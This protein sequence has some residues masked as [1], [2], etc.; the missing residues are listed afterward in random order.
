ML[1]PRIPHPDDITQNDILKDP[2][3]WIS[4]SV[5]QDE[6]DK[7]IT[8]ACEYAYTV[9]QARITSVGDRLIAALTG[10]Q[11]DTGV[12]TALAV[13]CS[14]CDNTLDLALSYREIRGSCA[15]CTPDMRA[16]ALARTVQTSEATALARAIADQTRHMEQSL[17]ITQALTTTRP[18]AWLIPGL[19][20][21]DCLTIIGGTSG[22]G[23]TWLALWIGMCVATGLPWLS[24]P[25]T[26]AR[27]LLVLLEGSNRDRY[28]RILRLAEGLGTT[29]AELGGWLDVYSNPIKSDD[30]ESIRE[31]AN[32]IDKLGHKLVVIDNL[33]E[34]RSTSNENSSDDMGAALQPLAGLAHR[35]EIAVV[36]IH[37]AN[38]RGEL[39]GSS[40]IRQHAD[41]VFEIDRRNAHNESNVRILRTKD[42]TGETAVERKYKLLDIFD[43]E[44]GQHV[45]VVPAVAEPPEAIVIAPTPVEVV[46][47]RKPPEP[48]TGPMPADARID[49]LL[50]ILPASSEALYRGLHP[51]SRST[52][53]KL[54]N[55][56]EAFG[57]VIER[58]KIWYA[59]EN[60]HN[61]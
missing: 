60:F 61:E 10:G 15:G 5:I 31:L 2:V 33:T 26:R 40:A 47:K 24:I 58:D 25:S 52:V 4:D 13:I 38:A 43:P 14:G 30:P 46:I 23:K 37:H 6:D 41:V 8:A 49:R 50:A 35:K 55:K 22:D 28:R 3:G 36:L 51:M 11:L 16:T 18:Q 9:E 39:R 45:A 29:V 19:V 20:A 27:T 21:S 32:T 44:T 1:A 42:R 12:W 56:A 34:V 48:M 57:A 53:L 7:T 54:R 59:N 17:D